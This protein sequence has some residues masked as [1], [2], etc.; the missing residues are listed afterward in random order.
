MSGLPEPAP[1]AGWGYS[2]LDWFGAYSM[3]LAILTALYHRGETGEGQWIDASQ[4]EV[5]IFLTP[6]QTLDWSA[7]DRVWH[8]YGN[9]SP[10]KPGAPHGIYRCAG[11]DRWIAIACFTDA[12][13]HALAKVAGRAGWLDDPRFTTIAD[14][15]AHQDALD[16]LVQSWTTGEDPF[17]LMYALQG[18]GVAAGVCQSAADR[19]DIDPQLRHLG[20]LTE[21]ES[22]KLGRWPVAGVPIRMSETPLHVGGLPNRGAPLY[23][24]DN[25]AILTGLLGM[26]EAEV[27]KLAEDGVL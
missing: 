5:G 24:E 26:T 20:W 8:R 1:P 6:V 14:R 3:A 23:G 13:W 21:L 19:C 25:V 12:D 10:Y 22:A 11:T 7:N 17:D 18:A 15:L 9:R 4:A 27:V 2:Y 16:V